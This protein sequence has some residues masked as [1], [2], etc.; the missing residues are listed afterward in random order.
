MRQDEMRK[1]RLDASLGT[2]KMEIFR[3]WRSLEERKVTEIEWRKMKVVL[4]MVERRVA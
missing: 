2:T 4:R 1:S 3:G